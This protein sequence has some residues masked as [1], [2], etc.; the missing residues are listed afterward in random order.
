MAERHFHPLIEARLAPVREQ[1]AWGEGELDQ[2]VMDAFN[3]PYGEPEH[4]D[5]EVTDRTVD[6]PHGPIPI[7]VYRPLTPAPVGGRPTLVW[8]HGG[9][10]MYGDMDMPEGDQAAR[11]VA[12]RADAVVVQVDYRLTTLAPGWGGDPEA[13]ENRFPVAQ[14][15]VITAFGWVLD[16]ADE[17]GIDPARVAIG[18][19]SAGGNIASGAVLRL[20]D[21]GRRPWQALLAYP[22][23]HAVMPEPSEELAEAKRFVPAPLGFGPDLCRVMNDNYLGGP[24]ED[25]P[26]YAFAGHADDLSNYPPTLIDNCEFDDLRASGEQFGRQ[27][28]AAGVDVEVVTSPGVP[29]GHLNLVGFPVTH[30]S[31]DRFAERLRRQK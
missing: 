18:G 27:L 12:G 9:A 21:E 28:A 14:D 29:H 22:V 23:A 7:R 10:F 16:H 31:L 19:A 4:L 17:L 25:A 26:A 1:P 3:A 11:G 8:L 2:A 15:D 5:L 6:G 20:T 13:P 30:A 24:S